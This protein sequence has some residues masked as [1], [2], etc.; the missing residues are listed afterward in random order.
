MGLLVTVTINDKIHDRDSWRAA[1]YTDIIKFVVSYFT[2]AVGRSMR[3]YYILQFTFYNSPM[4]S[5]GLANSDRAKFTVL[6]IRCRKKVVNI[7]KDA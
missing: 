7:I 6:N 1:R 2:S 4:T 3:L 5:A